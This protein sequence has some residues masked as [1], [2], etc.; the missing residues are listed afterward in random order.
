M[1]LQ[2]DPTSSYGY[3]QDYGEKIGR[4]VLVDQNEFNTYRID[5]LPPSPI[6]YPSKS[7]IEAAILSVPGEYFF[8]LQKG[9]GPMCFQKTTKITIKL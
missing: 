9:M 2:S 4:K 3:Y 1:R 5:G 6:C 7:A 8:L